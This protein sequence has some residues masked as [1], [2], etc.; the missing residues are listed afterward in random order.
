MNINIVINESTYAFAYSL[1]KFLNA[2]VPVF[3]FF[4]YILISVIEKIDFFFS[5]SSST[6]DEFQ[7]TLQLII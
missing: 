7:V 2:D 6:R 1:I 4:L 5:N 3:F